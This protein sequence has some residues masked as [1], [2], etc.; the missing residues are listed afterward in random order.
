MR[1]AEYHVA[2]GIALAP[3][4]VDATVPSL[5]FDRAFLPENLYEA[6]FHFDRA[7]RLTKNEGKQGRAVQGIA[8][9]CRMR[10]L[11]YAAFSGWSTIGA[12]TRSPWISANRDA[13]AMA[14]ELVSLIEK[15]WAHSAHPAHYLNVAQSG[16]RCIKNEPRAHIQTLLQEELAGP[17]GFYEKA[18]KAC[19]APQFKKDRIFNRLI[20]LSQFANYLARCGSKHAARVEVFDREII[21]SIDA[22]EDVRGVQGEWFERLGKAQVAH[23]EAAYF[24]RLGVQWVPQWHQLWILAPGAVALAGEDINW[25]VTSLE[26]YAVAKASVGNE[27]FSIEETVVFMLGHA[28]EGFDPSAPAWVQERWNAGVKVIDNLWGHFQRVRRALHEINKY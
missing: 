20:I 14:K 11:R 7:E 24:Y 27:P 9:D 18:L 1:R 2:A 3:Y 26:H 16:V 25:I 23:K 21:Q 15:E 19:E 8:L 6:H 17:N 5:T 22:G 10:L 28:G 4:T 12:L 13:Y